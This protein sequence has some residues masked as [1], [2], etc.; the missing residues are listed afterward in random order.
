MSMLSEQVKELRELANSKEFEM[1]EPVTYGFYRKIKSKLF[2]AA[3]TIEALSAKLAAG[4]MERSDMI[5]RNKLIKEIG[6]EIDGVIVKDTYSKGKN[7]GL[8]KAKILAEEHTVTHYGGGWI[9]AKDRLPTKEE[10]GNYRGN[11]LVTV[12][13]PESK[14]LYMEYKYATIRGKEVG[15]WIWCDRVNIPWEVIAWRKFP[16]PYRP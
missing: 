5:S 8:R 1:H 9:L 7:A 6:K 13:A 3:D 15:R 14:T 4:N 16:E 12:Y 2:K 11:F 10:C